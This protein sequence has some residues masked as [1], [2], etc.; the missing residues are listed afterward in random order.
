ME[1]LSKAILIFS[2]IGGFFVCLNLV[3]AAA[4]DVII[5]TECSLAGDGN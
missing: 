4:N 5:K 2:L 1:G 3:F